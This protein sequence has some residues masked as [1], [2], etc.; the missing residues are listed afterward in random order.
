M[1]IGSSTILN[2]NI[3]PKIYNISIIGIT[4]FITAAFMGFW[5]LISIMKSGKL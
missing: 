5:L 1:I 2:S 4:G 3:G